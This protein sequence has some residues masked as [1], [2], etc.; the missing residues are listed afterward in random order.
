ML[1]RV[2]ALAIILAGMS[3]PLVALPSYW[4]RVTDMGNGGFY[5]ETTQSRSAPSGL[6]LQPPEVVFDIN[7]VRG[8][9]RVMISGGEPSLP[10]VQTWLPSLCEPLGLGVSGVAYSARGR[11][12]V[13]EVTCG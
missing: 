13:A 11:R 6:F 12:I 2:G 7:G 1:L 5:M 3:G 4:G 8:N 10:A 9:Y